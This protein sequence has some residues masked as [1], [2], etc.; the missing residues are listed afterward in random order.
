M[1]IAE[2]RAGCLATSTFKRYCVALTSAK[3]IL[4]RHKRKPKWDKCISYQWNKSSSGKRLLWAFL[5]ASER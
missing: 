4:F 2:T 3:V 5:E 1:M